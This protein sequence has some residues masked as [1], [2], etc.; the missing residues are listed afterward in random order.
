[1]RYISVIGLRKYLYKVV[2]PLIT[3]LFY[4]VA[5]LSITELVALLMY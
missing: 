5:R 3:R 4:N 1:V 2:Q